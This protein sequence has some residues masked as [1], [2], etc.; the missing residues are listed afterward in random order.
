M[1][2]RRRRTPIKKVYFYQMIRFHAINGRLTNAAE[3]T[4]HVSD[5]AILRG[6]GVFDF[7]LIRNGQPLFLEDYLDRFF[8]SARLVELEM[9]VSR[10]ELRDQVLELKKANA[11]EKGAIRLVL[12]GGYAEDS[13]TPGSPNLLVLAH[14]YHPPMGLT[15]PEGVKLVL[16]E[17]QREFP[18]AKTLNY[19]YAIRMRHQLQDAG[20]Y[21]GLYH[22][23]QQ[24]L[25]SS[26][27]NIFFVFEGRVLAT[28]ADGILPGITRMH[29]LKI[30]D[31]LMPVEVRPISTSE[32]RHAR[33]AF[34][35]G[36]NKPIVP[37]IQIDEQIIGNGK[38][39][40]VT[41][42]LSAAWEDYIQI[43]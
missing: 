34:L 5:L 37:V 27:S 15:H 19:G 10:D 41:R 36:S 29:I 16:Q 35:T 4:L 9:P 32:I 42:Q 11:L 25:E 17:F 14:A 23:D 3:A 31:T 26:R 18:E 8:N 21:A 40:P 13:F 24:V 30:A 33:E 12:T 2:G 39:G 1:K 7:F 6:Y 22:Q 28:P 38:P 43:R 20:A